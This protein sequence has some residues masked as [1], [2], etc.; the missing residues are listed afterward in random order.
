[1]RRQ[2]SRAIE[3]NAFAEFRVAALLHYTGAA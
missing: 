1:M 2:L 3:F